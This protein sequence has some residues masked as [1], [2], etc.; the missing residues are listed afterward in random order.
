MA[1]R[2]D[3]HAQWYDQT[4]VEYGDLER[5]GSSSA[6][7]ADLLGAGEGWCL[8]VACG[9]GLHFRAIASTGRRVIGVD[10]SRDQLIVARRRSAIVVR[11][12]AAALP[13][14][15]GCFPAVVCTYLHTDAEDMRP[16][17]REVFRVLRSGG[18]FVYLGVHPCFRGHFVD[19][20]ASDRRVVLPG[21]WETGWRA[22]KVGPTSEMRRRVGARHVTLTELLGAL[23]DSGLRLVRV[24]EGDVRE[25]FAERLGLVAVRDHAERRP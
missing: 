4:F 22:R 13:F 17:F 24:D 20:S 10:I 16:V 23:L 19:V 1:A 6:Q 21:Y 11:G 5:A 12:D 2:Y 15:S 18:R 9:T 14:R 3:G 25:P 8:D 7:L